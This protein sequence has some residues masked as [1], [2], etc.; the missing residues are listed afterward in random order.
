[1][2]LSTM[3]RK[4]Q[5]SRFRLWLL[6]ATCLTLLGMPATAR[7]R[8]LEL[9]A[10]APRVAASCPRECQAIGLVSGYQTR[11]GTISNPYRAPSDGKV[12][13]FTVTLGRPTRDQSTY[14]TRLYGGPPRARISILRPPPRRRTR[15]RLVR[16]SEVVG[17][18]PYLGST[19]TFALDRPLSVKRG[20]IVALTVPTWAPAFGVGL[21][22]AEQWLS[23]RRR[24][25]NDN[26]QR[27][28]QQFPGSLRAYE[29][30]YLRARLLYSA[31]LIPDPRPTT[32][33]GR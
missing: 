11:Q 7:A 25:C 12:V 13:A 29:C 22:R 21:G 8:V 27:A 28:A 9:G 17:L 31:T 10:S 20:Y 30:R 5:R 23:A 3:N 33:R 1:M 2:F 14:F 24:P 6:V 15:H 19:P 32:R 18:S 26:L 16:H 4:S